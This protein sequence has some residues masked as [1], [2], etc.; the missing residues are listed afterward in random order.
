MDWLPVPL[1]VLN[2][3]DWTSKKKKNNQY[4]NKQGFL[5]SSNSLHFP[6][7]DILEGTEKDYGLVEARYFSTLLNTIE[8]DTT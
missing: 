2:G 4:N 5:K 7:E 3:N 8:S 1:L 6:N